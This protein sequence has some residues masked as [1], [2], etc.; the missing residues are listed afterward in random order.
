MS[1][2]KCLAEE[3]CLRCSNLFLSSHLQL[4]HKQ[5]F[6]SW[7]FLFIALRCLLNSWL[8]SGASA[9]CSRLSLHLERK[10]CMSSWSIRHKN[11]CKQEISIN[12]IYFSYFCSGASTVSGCDSIYFLLIF[13]C[14]LIL[15]SPLFYLDTCACLLPHAIIYQPQGFKSNRNKHSCHIHVARCRDDNN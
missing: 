13:L 14:S 3:L 12:H 1:F 2:F 8:L 11:V 6:C 15:T 7:W 4:L 9:W 5:I 10:V